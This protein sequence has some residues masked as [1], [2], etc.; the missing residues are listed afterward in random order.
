M[1]SLDD[2]LKQYPT[3]TNSTEII[4]PLDGV[5]S[6]DMSLP[7]EDE[8]CPL[9]KGTGYLRRDVPIDH[10]EFGK[11]I[12]C[13]CKRT[14]QS[15]VKLEQLRQL[16]NLEAL[17]RFTFENFK[18][19]YGFTDVQQRELQL[20]HEHAHDYAR[21][22]KGWLVFSGGYGCGK[23]HL[24]VAI[25]NYVV[26]Q[27]K[28]AFFVV[29]PDL[30]DYLRATFSPTSSVQYDERFDQIRQAPLLILDDLGAHSSTPWAEEKLFQLFNYR[31]NAQLPTVITTNL[32]L[33]KIDLRISSRMRDMEL[34]REIKIESGDVRRATFY[35]YSDLSILNLYKD[36]LFNTFQPNRPDL[37]PDAYENLLKAFNYA[38]TFAQ[39]PRNWLIFMGE[40][41]CGKTHL[42]AAIANEIEARNEAA[43]FV[44]VPDLL[45]YLRAAFSPQSATPYDRRF[46]EIRNT[47]LL[48]L[49]DLGM[50]SATPWATEKL[51]QLFNY[52]FN[53][54][55]PTVIT[56]AAGSKDMHP[57]FQSMMADED[58]CT[59]FIIKAPSY[60]LSYINDNLSSI[61]QSQPKKKWSNH[62]RNYS[63]VQRR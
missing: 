48:V 46:D 35:G 9:C 8:L 37:T 25:A 1:K 12:L 58:R 30:L 3:T 57:R 51:Y 38:R 19:N 17:S 36:K 22:P 42:A 15:S 31:Y 39:N 62:T 59:T 40:Y 14:Q 28:P 16:S 53:A 20:A 24:A 11:P 21:N 44:T 13:R 33:G 60:H 55:F 26:E 5:A 10:P 41:G 47:P 32:E 56:V 63:R 23:T 2:I 27:G 50:Q 7:N 4:K 54:R 52:R 34:S 61:P 49:D 18:P 6:L 29:V 45:D 43:L